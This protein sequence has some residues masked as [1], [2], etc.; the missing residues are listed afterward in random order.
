[1]EKAETYPIDTRGSYSNQILDEE[2]NRGVKSKLNADQMAERVRLHATRKV[3]GQTTIGTIARHWKTEYGI[4]MAPQSEK[5]WALTPGNKKLIDN[6]I[7]EKLASGEWELPSSTNKGLS[8]TLAQGA[9]IKADTIKNI[10]PRLLKLLEP[11]FDKLD[12]KGKKATTAIAKDLATITKYS[13][14]SLIEMIKVAGELNKA[15]D[16]QTVAIEQE[17]K[18]MLLERA[19]KK[20]KKG[21]SLEFDG[22]TDIEALREKEGIE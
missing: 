12:L 10:K 3:F 19:N 17:A 6:Y 9:R 18:R 7:E 11:G 14:E 13:E 15:K 4:Q 21:G 2:T 1:M 22:A 20:D 16:A 8:N 5:E